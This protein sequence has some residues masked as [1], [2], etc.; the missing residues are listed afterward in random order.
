MF[1]SWKHPKPLPTKK[2]C[3]SVTSIN[4]TSRNMFH[5]FHIFFITTG[6]SKFGKK[7]ILCD[8]DFRCSF[9]LIWHRH[10]STLEVCTFRHEDRWIGKHFLQL[11]DMCLKWV[12]PKIG[13][14]QKG[15]FIM[16]TLL[17]WMIWGYHYFRKHPNVF[18]A[19]GCCSLLIFVGRS[20]T[21]KSLLNELSSGFFA[22]REESEIIRLNNK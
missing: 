10:H 20:K 21:Q 3:W 8:W 22:L 19:V 18:G 4:Q 13:V 12:F 11:F 16:E 2:S 6:L 14:P 1:L 9:L 17:K 7:Q 5:M 15:W